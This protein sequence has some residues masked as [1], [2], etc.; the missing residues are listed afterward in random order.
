MFLALKEIAHSKGKFILITM[1]ILLISY[2]VFFLVSLAYGL[3]SS[4]TKGIDK[5]EASYIVFT[6]DAND[7][8]MM[9]YMNDSLYDEITVDGEKAKVGI[10][11]AV[12]KNSTDSEDLTK[13]NAYFFG[14]EN[15]SFLYPNEVSS[16]LDNEAVVDDSLKSEG[17]ALGDTIVLPGTNLSFVIKAFTSNSLFQTAPIIYINL[18]SW[19]NIRYS[20]VIENVYSAVI[21]KGSIINSPSE[22]NI[23]TIKDFKNTLPGYS[24]Q[25]AT[26][27]LMISFLIIISSFVL[28]IFVFVLTIQKSPIFGVMKAEGIRSS[29]IASSVMQQTVFLNLLGIVFGFLLTMLSGFFLK[30]KMPF[31]ANYLFYLYIA[32]GFTIFS[33]LGSL[34]SVKAVLKIDPL[35]AIG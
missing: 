9:S 24:A 12:I 14:V 11:P 21:V 29:Y 16:L 26:F 28:G 6:K 23:Y 35:K 10:Y 5:I 20:Y 7:S 22:L 17:Y 30:D 1:V 15:G 2:L 32:L 19:K 18:S 25:V 27:S 34:F 8:V 3:A 31:E 13:S 4:Y 33:L